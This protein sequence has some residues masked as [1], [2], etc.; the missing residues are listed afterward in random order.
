M[1]FDYY[2]DLITFWDAIQGERS[3]KVGFNVCFQHSRSSHL[4]VSAGLISM[5]ALI[6]ERGRT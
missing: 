3:R 5:M 4:P 6:T 1:G 2:Q